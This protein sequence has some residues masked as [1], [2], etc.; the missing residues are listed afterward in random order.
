MAITEETRVKIVEKEIATYRHFVEIIP[1]LLNVF[2][3]FDGKVINKRLQDALVSALHGEEVIPETRR[4][5]VNVGVMRDM[6]RVDVWLYDNEIKQYDGIGYDKQPSYSYFR[7]ENN[8]HRYV[9]PL[10]TCTDMTESGKLRIKADEIAKK[11]E[12]L[13]IELEEKAVDLEME[14]DQIETMIAERKQ[15]ETLVNAFNKKYSYHIKDV[16]GVSC[17]LENTS[18]IQYRRYGL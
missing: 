13:A 9:F 4:Y 8:E 5:R 16:F 2:R 17:R 7:I 15:I 6:L 14:L 3:K 18:S 10:A 12:E 1:T 11:F